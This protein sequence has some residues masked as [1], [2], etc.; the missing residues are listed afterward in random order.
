M[1]PNTSEAA[2]ADD[3][4]GLG[5]WTAALGGEGGRANAVPE[6]A[7]VVVLLDISPV[8]VSASQSS[9]NCCHCDLSMTASDSNN[10]KIN[11]CDLQEQNQ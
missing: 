9:Q 5:G 6:A 8:A 1:L 7:G 2:P 3:C 10:N 4:G 11:I